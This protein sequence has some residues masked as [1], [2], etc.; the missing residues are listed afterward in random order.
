[1]ADIEKLKQEIAEMEEILGSECKVREIMVSELEEIRNNYAKPRRSEIIYD[2][3]TP[4]IVEEQSVEDYNVTLFL[5]RDGYFKKI[6]PASLRMNDQQKYKYGDEI[7]QV[8]ETTNV[9]ELLF[10][11]NKCQVYKSCA[12]DFEDSK[13]SVLGDFISAKLEMEEGECVNYLAVT[14]DY[15]GYMLF[16]FENG[17]VAK[18]EM[19]SYATKTNRKKLIKAYSDKN[20]LATA[21]QLAQDGDCLLT[22]SSGRMLL[23]HSG[24]I[25]PKSTKD[26]QGVVIMTLRKT[27]IVKDVH[28]YKE[29]MLKSPARF[30]TKNLPAAGAMLTPEERG[31]EQLTF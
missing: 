2:D 8:I 30:R 21:L 7:A 1:M 12:A 14:H 11:T 4:E 9:C 5:T 20:P 16:A 6:T 17:K 26:S 19:A 28:E 27:S 22:A 31:E 23:F 25:A 3:E 10:F 24:A 13:S 15:S 29:G 18:V